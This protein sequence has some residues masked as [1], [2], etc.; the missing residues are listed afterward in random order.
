MN[1]NDK[2]IP[3][4]ARILKIYRD[5]I[6]SKEIVY[7]QKIDT[8]FQICEKYGVSRITGRRVL[9]DLEKEGLVSRAR[10]KGTFCIWKSEIEVQLFPE[11]DLVD[12]IKCP[13]R[14]VWFKELSRKRIQA[15][16]FT[17][18]TMG[19]DEGTELAEFKQLQMVDEVKVVYIISNI[20][21]SKTK[22]NIKTSTKFKTL[23]PSSEVQSTLNVLK[24]QPVLLQ[25]VFFYDETNNVK[26]YD[27][28]YYRG[29]SIVNG[30][31]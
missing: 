3:E 18:L 24:D 12:A 9:S 28:Y 15:D 25:E 17:A 26:Q 5:Q 13:G 14:K 7:G 16:F 31:R 2:S 20:V 11:C 27:Q 6:K 23:L 29:D 19:I 21:P 10:G 30:N 1:K 22:N 8:E 4:Y